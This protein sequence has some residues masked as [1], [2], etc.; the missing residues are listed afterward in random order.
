VWSFVRL[1]HVGAV[2]ASGWV[3]VAGVC[4]LVE[5][6]DVHMRGSPGVAFVVHSCS[7]FHLG[8]EV[9]I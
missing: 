7:Y 2:C 5:L 4:R 8:C 3:G 9:A 6:G 1:P